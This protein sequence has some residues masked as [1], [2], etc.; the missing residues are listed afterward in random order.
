M[1]SLLVLVVMLVY[2]VVSS[3]NGQGEPGNASHT[4]DSAASVDDSTYNDPLFFIEGQLCQH[5]REI[6]QDKSGNLWLGTNVYDIMRYDG[7]KLEYIKEVDGGRITA[8]VEDDKGNVWFGTYKGLIKYDGKRFTGYTE[9]DGLL[10]NEIWSLC[11]DSK[12]VIWIGNNKGVSVFDGKE[13]STIH[14][15]KGEV[16]DTNTIYSY[17][18]IVSIVEDKDGCLWFGTDGFGVCKYDGNV[19]KNYTTKD[20]LCDNT[21][22]E[23][24][25][26]SKGNIWIGTFWGGV[27]MY[28]G[29]TFTNFTKDGI[30]TG[31]EVGAFFED[32]NGDIWLAAE[33]N[34][35]YKYDGK[36]FTN[37]YKEAGL[38]TNGILSIY[39]DKQNRFWFGGWGG[40]FRYDGKTFTPVTKEGPWGE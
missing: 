2:M 30:I 8:I 31:V 3:C 38:I 39:R 10:N 23:M 21:I 7:V 36:Q 16:K 32:N 14:V 11:L 9:N 24:L 28:D 20:G 19:F 13:F 37:L 25:V 5:L 33:N 6:Y 17:D 15:P 26:D 1:S 34:G 12:G 35:V 4:V 27:S 18:R 22:S 29:K 40:L